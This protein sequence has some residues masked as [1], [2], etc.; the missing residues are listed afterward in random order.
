M[1]ARIGTRCRR[2]GSP[3]SRCRRWCIGRWPR[4]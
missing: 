3:A 1:L 2:R 4:S